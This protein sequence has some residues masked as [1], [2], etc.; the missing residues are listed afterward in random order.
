ML[1]SKY[2]KLR[3]TKKKTLGTKRVK[4]IS[5]TNRTFEIAEK[6]YKVVI[7]ARET[8]LKD[9]VFYFAQSILIIFVREPE[10]SVNIL[11]QE[12]KLTQLLIEVND[13]LSESVEKYILLKILSAT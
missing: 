4:W 12:N 9:S 8:D 2:T 6:H 1:L 5:G 13:N 10:N 11:I 3:Q 7:K